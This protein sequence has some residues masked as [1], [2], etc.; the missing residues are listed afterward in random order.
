MFTFGS[1]CKAFP[2]LFFRKP[3]TGG[4]PF[5][6]VQRRIVFSLQV[7]TIAI[8]IQQVHQNVQ[9]DEIR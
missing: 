8:S 6:S 3:K 7:G 2:H 4:R 5:D 9:S 1:P